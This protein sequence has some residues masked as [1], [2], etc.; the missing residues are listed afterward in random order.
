ME[1]IQCVDIKKEYPYEGDST[2]TIENT[3]SE[4]LCITIA[5]RIF[6]NGKWVMFSPN[7]APFFGAKVGDIFIRPNEKIDVTWYKNRKKGLEK[8][9]RMMIYTWDKSPLSHGIIK[10][11]CEFQLLPKKKVKDRKAP[12]KANNNALLNK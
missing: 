6:K 9:A 11:L 3:G 2:F 12:R 1:K 4:N 5:L 7:M 10:N 8:G